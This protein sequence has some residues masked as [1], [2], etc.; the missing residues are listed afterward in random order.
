MSISV[1]ALVALTASPVVPGPMRDEFRRIAAA[2][3]T[4]ERYDVAI[5]V[6]YEGAH[7]PVP[8]H[9]EVKCLEKTN[10][11]RAISN[12]SILENPRWSIAINR[13]THTLTVTRR[14]AGTPAPVSPNPDLDKILD[15]WLA[16]GARVSGGQLTPEGRHWVFQPADSSHLAAELYTDPGTHLIRR[17]I[18][19]T[20][21]RGSAAARVN[22]AYEWK[23]AS[24]LHEEE[25]TE[26]HYIVTQGD[27]IEPASSYAAYRI[28][29]ADR[30]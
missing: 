10:C 5:D 23:D 25:F 18:Y 2:H 24:H 9:A 27:R 22:I 17:I 20:H 7:L 6:R 26:S 12:I 30:H 15:A 28:I 8:I 21:T 1:L 11:I 19:Q 29:R 13:T 4:L 16:K 3:Q 14:G